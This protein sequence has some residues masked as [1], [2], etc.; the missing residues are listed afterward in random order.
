V[1]EPVTIMSVA[2]SAASSVVGFMGQQEAAREQDRAYEANRRNALMAF[3]NNNLQTNLR[4]AQEQEAAAQERQ[5]TSLEARAAR[6]RT[7]V[8][9]GEM[10]VQGN[11]VDLLLQDIVD[12]ED[13]S[14]GNTD[15]NLDWSVAQ[16]EASKKGQSYQALDRINSVQRGQKPSFAALGLSIANAGLQGYSTYRQNQLNR[17]RN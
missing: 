4:I 12:A 14:I 8:A 11:T 10:G 3:E 17:L 15:K 9:A 16:H 2:L 1:C 7:Q 13:R 5:K 6:A